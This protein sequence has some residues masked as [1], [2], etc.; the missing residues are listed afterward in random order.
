M[1][2]AIRP[3]LDQMR[4]T[5]WALPG[6]C[7]IYLLAGALFFPVMALNLATAMV[8]G[9][10]QG[11]VFSLIGCMLSAA[12]Y[13]YLGRTARRR[14]FDRFLSHPKIKRLDNGLQTAGV[15]GVALLRLVPVAPYTLFNLAAGVSS[16]PF[17]I[18]ITGT[19][20]ALLP[21]AVTRG[22]IGDSLMNLFLEPTRKDMIWL[23]LGLCLW[24]AVMAGSH[25][26][27]KKSARRRPNPQG[28]KSFVTR[29]PGTDDHF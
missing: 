4:G 25:F 15:A 23:T 8:F 16:L 5:P 24:V 7:L 18:Y 19:F 17:R 10:I 20:L 2:A 27:L 21:G 14:H 1:V 12:A 22:I 29:S 13:F 3:W 9:K 26:L 11:V 6:I 28:T